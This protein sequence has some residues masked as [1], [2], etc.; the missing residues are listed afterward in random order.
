MASVLSRIQIIMEANT[1]NYNNE[2]RRARENSGK[3]FKGIA[4]AAGKMAVGAGVALAGLAATSLKTAG[5]FE[6][7][8]G[9]VKAV[10]NATGADFTKLRDTAKELGSTTA[11]SATEAANGMEFL[12]MSGMKTEQILSTIPNALALAAAGSLDLASSADILSNIMTGLGLKAEESG[13]AADVLAQAA[14]SSNVDISM[15][16]ESMKYVAPIAK[17]LGMSLEETA[18]MVGVLGNAGIQGSEA[19]TALRSVYARFATHDKA[20]GHFKAMGINIKDASGEMKSMTTLT[21]ELAVAMKDMGADERLA[22]FKEM[23]GTEAMSA[24]AVSVDAMADGSLPNLTKELENSEGAAEKMAAIRMEG[25]EGSFKTLASAWEGFQIELADTGLLT[26][27][28]SVV[29]GLA[30]GLQDFTKELPAISASISAFF[31]RA[32]VSTALQMALEGI[33][34]AFSNL[35]SVVVAVGEAIA[36]VIEWF[37]EHDKFSQAL[38]ISI[39]LVATGFAV[40]TGIVWLA[41]AAMTAFAT[42]MAIATAPITAIVIALVAVTAAGVYLY[43]NWDTIKAKGVAV[44]QGLKDTIS[45]FVDSVVQKFSDFFS[46]ASSIF[47]TIG[48]FISN[49]WVSVKAKAVE[50]FNS[51]PEPVKQMAA[52]ILS[53]FTGIK[54]GIEVVFNFISGIVTGAIEIA[55]SAWASIAEVFNNS[56]EGIKAEFTKAST[57]VSDAFNVISEVAAS[58]LAVASGYLEALGAFYTSIFEGMKVVASGILAAIVGVFKS[59]FEAIKAVAVTALTVIASVFNTGF[60]LIKNGIQ[61]V[62]NVI[63]ALIRGDMQGVVNAFKTGLSN[64]ANIVKTGISNI[65]TAFKTL[66]TRLVQIGSDAITGFINGMKGKIGEAVAVVTN[67]VDKVKNAF[68]RTKGLDIHSPSRVTK[69][70]GKNTGEGFIIGLSSTIG[71]AVRVADEMVS[72]IK[73]SFSLMKNYTITQKDFSLAKAVTE[74]NTSVIGSIQNLR[75]EIVL[76]GNDSKL[77]AFEYEVAIGSLRHASKEYVEE[78]RKGLVEIARLEEQATAND[79]AKKSLQ[80]RMKLADAY[81]KSQ[82]DS[83]KSLS[84]SLA[85]ADEKRIDTLTQQ[86]ALI[87]AMADAT[88]ASLLSS[89]ALSD[90]SA[91]S[92][93]SSVYDTNEQSQGYQNLTKVNMNSQ[94]SEE[95]YTSKLRILSALEQ[96]LEVQQALTDL[97]YNQSEKRKQIAID[98]VA[99]NKAIYNEKLDFMADSYGT[100]T[101]LAKGFAGENSRI[102]K[103]M[104]AVQKAHTLA[105]ILL[106]NKEALAIAWASAP[107]PANL[108]AVAMAALKTGALAAAAQAIMPSV[109]GQAHDGLA[110]VPKEGTYILDEGERVVRPSDNKKLTKFLDGKGSG[111]GN[112]ITTNVTI[113]SDGKADV[114]SNHTLGKELGQAIN[115]AVQKT[116]RTELRQGGMLAR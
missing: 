67:L 61:T 78:Y 68:T 97:E 9:G 51:M 10:S 59:N 98:E 114:Q 8:M 115:A 83:L 112:N 30:K 17:Q 63:K 88:E 82:Q 48:N 72:S 41:A 7:A 110:N 113:A 101:D 54:A 36:P 44:W 49:I 73:A 45:G 21:G 94:T 5:S 42:V 32:D 91:V 38:A 1:A 116:L 35:V 28:T 60:N 22:V 76:F 29:S 57:I 70:I 95:E 58:V 53:V 69:K 66:G 19:G 56:V 52:N 85:T 111:T 6:A 87:N 106:K 75:K 34:T 77:A 13:R 105:N 89:R 62:M 26:G 43:Q 74:A 104:F 79:T 65:V 71:G 25:L 27:A 12:A 81:Y 11:F 14:A 23:A 4:A 90:V 109:S 33:K 102:Y 18:A 37:K 24:L 20:L 47:T 2:L 99:A 16:G 86:L 107:F 50:V 80:D 55:R 40:Y 92:E 84:N 3:T 93:Y 103:V 96:T 31:N 100:L 46:S 15:L 108:G 39:G 64:A